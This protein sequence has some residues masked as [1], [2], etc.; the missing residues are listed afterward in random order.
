M[1]VHE[2]SSMELSKLFNYSI[3]I[4][5][6][7]PFRHKIGHPW[8]I[9]ALEFW[10]RKTKS[11]AIVVTPTKLKEDTDGLLSWLMAF[12][13]KAWTLV[14]WLVLPHQVVPRTF[15]GKIG[16][17]WHIQALEFCIRKTKWK[18]IMVTPTKLNQDTKGFLSGLMAFATKAWTLIEGLVLP[19]QCYQGHG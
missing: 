1:P 8:R 11:K 6:S 18:A 19:H 16:H 9:Q 15:L 2:P 17:P 14:E 3:P 4:P 13:T 7:Y 10:I 5:E 12:A